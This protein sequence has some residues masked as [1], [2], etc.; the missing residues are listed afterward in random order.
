MIWQKLQ[1][2]GEEEKNNYISWRKEW[3]KKLIK[4]NKVKEREGLREGDEGLYNLTE[5]GKKREQ[6]KG[7]CR[8][9]G[10]AESADV[11]DWMGIWQVLSPVSP[12]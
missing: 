1:I 6:K 7:F 4:R 10:A 8:S 5:P 12:V 9:W 3:E 2:D 11:C